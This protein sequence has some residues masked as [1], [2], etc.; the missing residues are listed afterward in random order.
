M[1]YPNIRNDKLEFYYKPCKHFKEKTNKK[2]I[3]VWHKSRGIQDFH[4]MCKEYDYVAIGGIA[5][6]EIKKSE[7]H[8]LHDL[9]DIA[10]SY[11][12]KVHGL[13]KTSYHTN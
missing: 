2:T 7:H 4:D 8:I 5:N 10:H 12:C 9:C 13:G 3:P 11:K 6:N 1:Y